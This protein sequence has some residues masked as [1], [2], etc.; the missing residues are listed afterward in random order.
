[1][2]DDIKKTLN[3]RSFMARVAG[4]A[5]LT[6]GAMTLVAGEARAQ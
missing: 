4:G 5:A 6:G 3:R 2:A 1:M